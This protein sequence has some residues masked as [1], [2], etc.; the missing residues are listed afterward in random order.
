[1]TEVES[2]AGDLWFRIFKYTVYCLLIYNVFVFLRDDIAASSETFL[3]RVTWRNVVE[4]YSAT[5]DTAGSTAL[6]LNLAKRG[7][8]ILLNQ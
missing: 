6:L 1:M 4:A 3:A 8:T 7:K 5:I 2:K